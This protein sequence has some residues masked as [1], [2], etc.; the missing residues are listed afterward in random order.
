MPTNLDK[1]CYKKNSLTEVIARADFVS[2]FPDFDKKL[3]TELTEIALKRFPIY[4]PQ[5]SVEREIQFKMELGP[6]STKERTFTE[7]VFHGKERKKT[8]KIVPQAM[9]VTYT[10]YERFEDFRDEFLA[11]F[12]ATCKSFPDARI[13]RLGLRFIN[14]VNLEDLSK[15]SATSVIDWSPYIN[16]DLLGLFKFASGD[17]AHVS[18][19]FH[20]IE[21][22]YDDAQLRFQF[23]MPNP[24]YPAP[25]RRPIFVLDFDAFSQGLLEQNEIE[26]TLERFHSLIQQLFERSILNGL[27]DRLNA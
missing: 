19:V 17:Q 16:A 5:Q 20:N 21:F 12:A 2:P 13:G 24:E 3:P 15:T 18:R 26:P 14:N 27:R 22:T 1:I 4:E 25:I 7:W 8:L 9:M 6:I 11:I 23:G 10:E